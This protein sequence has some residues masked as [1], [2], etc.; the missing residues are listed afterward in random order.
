[1]VEL[2]VQELQVSG[3]IGGLGLTRFHWQRVDATTPLVPDANSAAAAI[4]GLISIFSSAMPSDIT[5]SFNPLVKLLDVSTGQVMGI[6]NL[7]TV[8]APVTGGSASDYGAGLGARINWSTTSVHG[9]RFLRSATYMVP[10]AGNAYST[11]GS[12]ASSVV[13][14][15]NGACA[16]Y[17]AALNTAALEGIAWHRPPKGTFTGGAAGLISSGQVSTTPAGLRSR[18]S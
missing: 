5:W 11:N 15:G 10:L 14:A 6:L 4:H 18:R 16:T 12:I 3:D 9:R 13:T 8:P 7:T 17:L 1:M 2:A